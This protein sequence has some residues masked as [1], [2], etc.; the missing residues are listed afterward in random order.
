MSRYWSTAG[1]PGTPT[2]STIVDVSDGA[3]ELIRKGVISQ[4]EI[5]NAVH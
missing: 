1:R 3:V 2:P 4:E 5:E